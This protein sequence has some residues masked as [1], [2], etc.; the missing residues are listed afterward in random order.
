ASTAMSAFAPPD[1]CVDARLI[2][3]SICLRGIVWLLVA[4]C[5]PREPPRS[6]YGCPRFRMERRCRRL[7]EGPVAMVMDPQVVLQVMHAIDIGNILDATAVDL[8]AHP[9]VQ[10]D[11]SVLYNHVDK[12]QVEATFVFET[13]HDD[14]PQHP[15][16]GAVTP[17]RRRF[18]AGRVWTG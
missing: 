11:L 6:R 4:G 9:P 1:P 5:H 2:G 10:R 7:E 16:R 14:C 13:F 3:S 12:T 17:A 8:V 15:V 18:H